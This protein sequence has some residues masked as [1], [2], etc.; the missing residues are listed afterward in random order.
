MLAGPAGRACLQGGRARTSAVGTRARWSHPKSRL[1][2]VKISFAARE[3]YCTPLTQHPIAQLRVPGACCA[4]ALL[5]HDSHVLGEA[6]CLAAGSPAPPS[7]ENPWAWSLATRGDAGVLEPR[8]C[9][10]RSKGSRPTGQ[11][12]L[13]YGRRDDGPSGHGPALGQPVERNDSSHAGRLCF[14]ANPK[15]SRVPT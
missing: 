12:L 8:L 10:R 5:G 2:S 11:R 4:V 7:A 3:S 15:A 1:E 9:V 14:F 6:R 13:V